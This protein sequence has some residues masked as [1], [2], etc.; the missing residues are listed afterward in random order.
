MKRTGYDADTG[1]YYFLDDSDGSYW[2]GK[3][4]EKFGVMSKGTPKLSK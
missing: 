4:K 2:R 1:C 3:P